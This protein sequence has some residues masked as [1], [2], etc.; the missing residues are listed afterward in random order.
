MRRAARKVLR[1]LT[2]LQSCP[3]HQPSRNM[4]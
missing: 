3:C 4:R 1:P 2:E